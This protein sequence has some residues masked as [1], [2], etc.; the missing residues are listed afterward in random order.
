MKISKNNLDNIINRRILEAPIDYGD[1][2]ERMEPSLQSKIERGQTPFSD[3]PAIPT[4]R[5]GGMSFEERAASKRFADLVSKVSQYTGL[6]NFTTSRNGLIQMVQMTQSLLMNILQIE[7]RHKEYLERLAVD[8]VLKDMGV[9]NEFFSIDAKLVGVGEIDTSN[10]KKEPEDFDEEEIMNTFQSSDIDIDQLND[11]LDN[12]NL[13]KVKRRF[14]NSLIQGSAKKGHYMFN[15]VKNELDRLDPNLVNMYGSLMSLLDIAYWMFSDEQVSMM[16]G[17]SVSGS[18]EVDY[19]EENDK[20]IIKAKGIIFPI[21]VHE[22]IKGVMDVAGT[23]GLPDDPEQAKMVMAST[24]TMA[25]ETWDI[26]L[27]P[28]FWE[29]FREAY[30]NKLYDEDK[31][32]IQTYLFSKFSALDTE[33]FFQLARLIMRGNPRGTEI[34]NRMVDEIVQE[35]NQQH[36]EYSSDNDDDDEFNNLLGDLGINLS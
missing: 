36:D 14:I 4:G 3:N 11:A 12:F 10:F 15:L 35:L 24:D 22:I 29:K 28:I 2:P 30:P 6:R 5:E 32:W 25:D 17:Q 18:E 8:L 9:D 16:M 27:G 21:L 33:E 13:E 20:T 7:S 34:L 31:K 1:S 23:H 19:D 26:R